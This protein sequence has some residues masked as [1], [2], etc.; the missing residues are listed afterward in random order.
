MKEEKG[1]RTQIFWDRSSISVF[2]GPIFSFFRAGKND[3]N[4]F[5]GFL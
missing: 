3:F 4:T 5:K 1:R 2:W